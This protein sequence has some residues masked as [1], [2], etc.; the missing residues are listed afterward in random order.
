MGPR[1]PRTD[2]DADRKSNEDIEHARDAA[3]T[4]PVSR[5]LSDLHDDRSDRRN[6]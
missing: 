3:S 4:P 6:D 1:Q 5:D 2:R